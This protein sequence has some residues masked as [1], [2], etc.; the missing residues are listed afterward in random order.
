MTQELKGYRV[1]PLWIKILAL[2]LI[3]APLGNI[4]FSFLTV[5]V[6]NLREP[7]TWI[8]WIRYVKPEVWA[9]NLMLFL[10][11]VALLWVRTWSHSMAAV[12]IGAVLIY[13]IMTFKETIFIGPIAIA[14]GILATMG[15]LA[16][17]Y[18]R[19]FRKPYFHP[20][21]RWWET[22]PRFRVDLPVDV[23]SVE[24]GD[25]LSAILLDISR[26]GIL[27]QLPEPSPWRTGE[28]QLIELPNSLK[29]KA[30][31]IRKHDANS[32]G[33]NFTKLSWKDG[34]ELKH[35]IRQLEVDPRNLHR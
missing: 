3:L 13:N 2:V 23:H 11:G 19:D 31:V 15:A 14:I 30:E 32:F 9:L 10:S 16:I 25:K 12:S 35:F 6:P 1:K 20:R 5:G 4:F 34:R 7:G 8:Y 21:L 22:S 17:L 26:S 28:T 29:I 18:H 33:L 24:S 27:L